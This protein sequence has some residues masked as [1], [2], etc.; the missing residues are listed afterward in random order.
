VKA[1]SRKLYPDEAFDPAGLRRFVDARRSFLGRRSGGGETAM[2]DAWQPN[3]SDAPVDGAPTWFRALQAGVV[4]VVA[5][6]VLYVIMS[7]AVVQAR[8]PLPGH[9]GPKEC[10]KT[11]PAQETVAPPPHVPVLS[12]LTLTSSGL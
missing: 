1:D 10:R 2:M 6:L 7:F 8:D 11:V 5:G 3:V 12:G 9:A 4:G